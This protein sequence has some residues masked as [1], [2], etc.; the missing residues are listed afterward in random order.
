MPGNSFKHYILATLLT[1]AKLPS[2]QE[3]RVHAS[4]CH[5]YKIISGLTDFTD[6]PIEPKV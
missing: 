5:L 4:L 3:R 6:A 1:T 2:L